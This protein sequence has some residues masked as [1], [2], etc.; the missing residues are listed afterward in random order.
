MLSCLFPLASW[1]RFLLRK[2]PSQCRGFLFFI[3]VYGSAGFF[4]RC[5]LN[6][7]G[8]GC[9]LFDLHRS[10]KS[11]VYSII[12][13]SLDCVDY[14]WL[15]LFLKLASN[16]LCRMHPYPISRTNQ[17]LGSESSAFISSLRP[18]RYFSLSALEKSS[19][20]SVTCDR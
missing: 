15:K 14:N 20:G 13:V 4:L 16:P 19:P 2:L 12:D 7:G 8:F 6:H 5:L 11:L 1:G 9:R 17:S 18:C 3:C 10:A